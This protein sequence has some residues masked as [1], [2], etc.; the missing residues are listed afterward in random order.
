MD[1][2]PVLTLAPVAT[3]MGAW[4]L[5]RRGVAWRRVGLVPAAAVVLAGVASDRAAGALTAWSVPLWLGMAVGVYGCWLLLWP[6]VRPV[7]GRLF[8]TRW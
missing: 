1:A 3:G 4:L 6:V 5:L 2:L 8:G 7:F